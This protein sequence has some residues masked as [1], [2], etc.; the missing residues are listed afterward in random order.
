LVK[1]KRDVL[2]GN[3]CKDMCAN[4]FNRSGLLVVDR[5]L[6][7]VLTLAVAIFFDL[8]GIKARERSRS[9]SRRLFNIVRGRFNRFNQNS[10]FVLVDIFP[11]AEAVCF[12]SENFVPFVLIVRRMKNNRDR[13]DRDSRSRG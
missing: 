2:A 6:S 11:H 4:L 7:R 1:K 5:N 3:S 10:G 12:H 8:I 9:H 13:G